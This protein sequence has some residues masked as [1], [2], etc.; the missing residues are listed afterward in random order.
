MTPAAVPRGTLTSFLN[1]TTN[2]VRVLVLAL[3]LLLLPIRLQRLHEE[4]V[5]DDCL[6]SEES[7]K[8]LAALS[9]G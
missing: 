8:S 6:R 5:Q 7:S 4:L 1:P 9:H 3:P 2:R